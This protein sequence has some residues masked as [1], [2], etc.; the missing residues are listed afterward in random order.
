MPI[1][2]VSP[3]KVLLLTALTLEVSGPNVTKI[4]HD[5]EIFILSNYLKSELRYCN[6]FLNATNRLVHKKCHISTNWLP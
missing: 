5:V 3:Q 1:F 4:A 2:A 6:Q